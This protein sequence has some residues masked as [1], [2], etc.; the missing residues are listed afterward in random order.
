[1]NLRKQVEPLF[2]AALQASSVQRHAQR[3]TSQLTWVKRWL[4]RASENH[5]GQ[6]RSSTHLSVRGGVG[7]WRRRC[8]LTGLFIRDLRENFVDEPLQTHG[9]LVELA[10][11]LGLL[12][13]RAEIFVG[14]VERDQHSQAEGV[15]G[16][17]GIGGGAHLLIDVR[18]QL[19]DVALV[20]RAPDRVGLPRDLDRDQSARQMASSC[21]SISATRARTRSRSSRSAVSSLPAASASASRARSAS[22]SW[23]SRALSPAARACSA[24]SCAIICTSRRTFSSRRSIGSSSVVRAAAAVF[25]SR[26][27]PLVSESGP[28]Q[29]VP[30]TVGTRNCQLP[31]SNSPT[32]LEKS[33][34][35]WELAIGG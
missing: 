11:R 29:M 7:Q 33:F 12:G 3:A 4:R 6:S 23:T 27:V 25:T 8:R 18:R 5:H 30:R 10:M 20:E 34:G 16:R 13:A 24:R 17:R 1:M 35:S 26:V 9:T 15:A 21:S 22:I 28:R 31:T 2:S 19:R 14:N 32:E